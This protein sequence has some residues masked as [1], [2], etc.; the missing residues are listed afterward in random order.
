MKQIALSLS[1]AGLAFLMTAI[2]G[3]PLLRI[4][5]YYKI[6]K[7]IYSDAYSSET[8]A[9]ADRILPDTTYLERYDCISLLDRPI[10]EPDGAA[11]AIRHPVVKPDRDVRGFQDVLIE[12]GARLKLPGFTNADGTASFTHTPSPNEPRMFFRTCPE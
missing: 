1:L 10:S 11:D 12:L 2:W 9:Y 7:I 6:G 8:V 5:R 3:G 4:L